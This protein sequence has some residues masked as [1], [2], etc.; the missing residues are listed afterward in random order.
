MLYEVITR[1]IARD[2]PTPEEST[3]VMQPQT[4]VDWRFL[5]LVIGLIGLLPD[6]VEANGIVGTVSRDASARFGIPG[7]I[8]V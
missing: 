2:E 5:G 7:G 8:L 3:E 4:I 6:L 1:E